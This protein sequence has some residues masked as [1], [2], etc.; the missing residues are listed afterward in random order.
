MLIKTLFQRF[1]TNIGLRAPEQPKVHFPALPV[2]NSPRAKRTSGQYPTLRAALISAIRRADQEH[3][4]PSNLQAVLR[5]EELAEVTELALLSYCHS[6]FNAEVAKL[7]M[8]VVA[9]SSQ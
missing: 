2:A 8:E 5:V 4:N 6:L 3:T 1:E 7:R 9:S